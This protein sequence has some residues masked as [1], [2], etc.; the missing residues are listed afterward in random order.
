VRKIIKTTI[1]STL[2]AS[3]TLLAN[4]SIFN[5]IG[6][7]LGKSYTSYSH[8]N[9]TGYIILGDESDDSF[10]STELYT[11]F[12]TM[13]N[14][15][16]END[17]RPYLSLTYSTNFDLKH[18]YLLA[19]LSKYY[20]PESVKLELYLGALLGYGMLD[21]K[22]DP[23][24]NS[25]SKDVDANGFMGGFQLGASYPI[26][27]KFSIG[28]NGKYLFT[29]YDTELKTANANATITH[30]RWSTIAINLEYSF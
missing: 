5:S 19:G 26:N 15:C 7:N 13:I 20:T 28:L 10:N 27:D 18:Q 12:N 23:L 1:T 14:C 17:I 21:W 8:K 29:D 22:Y 30:D 6:V 16:K 9:N 3:S 11:T 24:N 2:I 25:L 4:D